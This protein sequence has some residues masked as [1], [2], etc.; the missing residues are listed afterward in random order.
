VFRDVHAMRAHA[1][2]NP[3]KASRI[4]GRFELTP[5]APPA[6]ATDLFL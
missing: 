2:N 5:D 1:I 6:D 4:F 3:D